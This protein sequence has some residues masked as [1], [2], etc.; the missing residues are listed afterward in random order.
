MYKY[1]YIHPSYLS[2]YRILKGP[3]QETVVL[4]GLPMG[5]SVIVAL[6]GFPIEYSVIVATS[7]RSPYR[8][9]CNSNTNRFLYKIQCKS[10]SP[11]SILQPI[12][13]GYT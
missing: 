11:V 5:Y 2:T 10:S 8:I 7:N 13:I 6:T 12:N 1:M 4:T 3:P 9:Q